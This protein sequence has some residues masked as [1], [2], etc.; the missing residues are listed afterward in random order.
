MAPSRIRAIDVADDPTGWARAG[1]TVAGDA[2]H[3]GSLVVRLV[4]AGAEGRQGILSW[5]LEGT[6]ATAVDGLP[7]STLPTHDPDM[8]PPSAHRHV[9]GATGIDH[10]VLRTGDL[11]RTTSAMRDHGWDVR[12]TIASP[13]GDGRTMRF[14]LAPAGVD[15]QER[16]LLELIG[17]PDTPGDTAGFWG[18]AVTTPTLDAAVRR[19]GTDAIGPPTDAVQPGRRIATV[20]GHRIGVGV[21]LALMSPRA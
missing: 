7:V 2:V 3:L 9:N 6:D 1:F 15:G 11:D 17:D 13:R 18:L 14:L 10:L 8:L 21:P 12:R 16:L 20:R 5:A 4:G 19:L